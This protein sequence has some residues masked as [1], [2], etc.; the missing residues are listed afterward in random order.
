MCT[1]AFAF[2]VT[3][4]CNATYYRIAMILA[5][6]PPPLL[7]SL[8]MR[9]AG[10]SADARRRWSAAGRRQFRI[11]VAV[12]Q[13]LSTASAVEV[14]ASYMQS[15]A[16]VVVAARTRGHSTSKAGQL[17]SCVQL[18]LRLLSCFT[19]KCTSLGPAIPWTVRLC[20]VV[21]S[22]STG[23]QIRLVIVVIN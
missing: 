11:L 8:W 15:C 4:K 2:S 12:L 18:L 6:T 13:S 9:V 10:W 17:P 23:K 16:D 14:A 21:S 3:M 19:S 22:S 7:L 5:M 20:F 1:R